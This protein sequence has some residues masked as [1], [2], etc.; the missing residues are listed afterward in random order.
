MVEH[1]MKSLMIISIC[2]LR[3]RI[4]QEEHV[5]YAYA[6]LMVS[7]VLFF[8]RADVSTLWLALS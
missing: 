6:L 1:L 5:R 3:L 4:A 7:A 8:V 2:R